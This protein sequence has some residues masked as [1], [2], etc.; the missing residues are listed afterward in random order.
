MVTTMPTEIALLNLLQL[1][2]PALP[3]GAYC[4][5]EGLEYLCQE[6]ISN[7]RQLTQWLTQEL[8]HGAIRIEAALM[9][10][11]YRYA[12]DLERLEYWNHWL[13]AH[14]ET[15]ELRQQS[16]QMGKSLL[17]LLLKL[18]LN[19]VLQTIKLH[20][21]SPI[22]YA[23]MFG[24]AAAHWQVPLESALL[25]FLQSWASNL[26]IAGVKLIPLGQTAGQQILMN[27]HQVI[28]QVSPLILNLADDQLYCCS[29]GLGLASMNHE[30]QYSRLFRS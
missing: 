25:A 8:H 5:S 17:D 23:L 19:P 13:M 21:Q 28:V 20:W 26:I 18:N 29:L 1:A 12:E 27:T 9:L 30:S 3:L 22:H 11:G 15:Q 24:V 10:R 6:D 16:G 2:S 14:K 4:Y 7:A